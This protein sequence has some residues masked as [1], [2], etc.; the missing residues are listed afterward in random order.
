MGLLK[1]DQ[2]KVPKG[3][4]LKQYY[5][6]ILNWHRKNKNGILARLSNRAKDDPYICCYMELTRVLAP[7]RSA[8]S[9]EI[10]FV[11]REVI[12]GLMEWAYHEEDEY[13]VKTAAYAQHILDVFFD[14]FS[15]KKTIQSAQ[16]SKLF[17]E[18]NMSDCL[19]RY[20]R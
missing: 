19:R 4:S 3:L 2:E 20:R 7:P 12:G 16:A 18:Y 9:E 1:D 11:C 13:G 6:R 10:A 15:G 17:A 14:G 5:A 8:N